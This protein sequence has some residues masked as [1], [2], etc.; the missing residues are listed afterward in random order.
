MLRLTGTSIFQRL[1]HHE[2]SALIKRCISA[3]ETYNRV[4]RGVL[5][6]DGDVAL[7]LFA[8]GLERNILRAHNRAHDAPG[9][10]LGEESLGDLDV[11]ENAQTGHPNRDCESEWLV[12]QHP[13]QCMGVGG[14][15]AIEKP[16]ACPTKDVAL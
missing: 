6:H 13:A 16:F 2:E 12:T 10:L 3:R 1:E 5:H 7:Y 8:H 14:E 9:I 4:D 11:E 15:H